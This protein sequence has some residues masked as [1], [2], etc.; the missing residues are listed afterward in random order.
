MLIVDFPKY[1]VMEMD[2]LCNCPQ[3]G[4]N[5]DHDGFVLDINNVSHTIHFK[6][7]FTNCQ[8][9]KSLLGDLTRDSKIK[10]VMKQNIDSRITWRFQYNKL[11]NLLQPNFETI[12]VLTL[13][14]SVELKIMADISPCS[15]PARVLLPQISEVI[16][17]LAI[18]A[19]DILIQAQVTKE[20]SI[21]EA[22]NRMG[23]TMSN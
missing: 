7:V 19:E 9:V 20:I 6:I 1:I 3:E 17:H 18:A 23:T 11:C 2:H 5:V 10:V 8:P 14:I 12:N 16:N 13:L 21:T 4:E 22:D 15:V